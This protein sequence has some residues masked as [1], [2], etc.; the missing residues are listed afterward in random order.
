MNSK[1]ILFIVSEDSNNNRNNNKNCV[2]L[3]PSDWDDWF[4]YSTV[5]SV[6]YFDNVGEKYY[7]GATKIGEINQKSR[8]PSIPRQFEK[9]DIHFFSLGQDSSFYEN[10][11][12]IS[13]SVRENI[14]KALNDIAYDDELYQSIKDHNI[15][16]IS[17]MRDISPVSVEG[18]FR[19]LARGNSIL[20]KYDFRFLSP[21]SHKSLS[22]NMELYFSV[23]PKS[24]PPTNIHVIIG[25]NGV[26]K[27]HLF[28]NMIKSLLLPKSTK[29]GSF[30]TNDK[31]NSDF[32]ANL[33]AV[34][35]SVFEDKTP[36]D[37]MRIKEKINYSYIGLKQKGDS[38]SDVKSSTVLKN[39]FAKSLLKC[40]LTGKRE[41][42][43]RSVKVLETDPIFKDSEISKLTVYNDE[44]DELLSEQAKSLFLKLSSGHKII[45][46]T[47]T[48]LVET[49]EEKSLIILDEPETYLH[50]PL[51]SAFVRSLSSLLIERNAVA[52]IGTHSPV[53]LQEVPKSCVWKLR[54]K[55]LESRADR[56]QIESF[57]ENVGTLTQE[58]FG[59]E[60]TDS[61]FHNILK[62][63]INKH[64][65]YRQAISDLN[66]QLGFEGRAILRN[67]VLDSNE[68]N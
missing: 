9:L 16:R 24:N 1:N 33:I 3:V 61:G 60:V 44:N 12:N 57:G 20:T 4:K 6:Y 29:Y 5:F 68:E 21:K 34:S 54:R 45:I 56:L 63:L 37:N 26:G 51:L 19:R 22:P 17:L 64:D 58:V 40:F 62:Q 53:V 25:R 43:L 2:I 35:F 49:I 7:L 42:W 59:L 15:A 48:R 13:E 31:V 46:L 66:N 41:R 36:L 39:E 30:Q 67:L 55:G 28:N 50:P 47:I 32:F 38:K 14:L 52:I 18:Q 8:R 27:T 10:L 65:N 11:N 23:E